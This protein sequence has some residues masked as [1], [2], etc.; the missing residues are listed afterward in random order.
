MM[1]LDELDELL[2]VDEDD[3]WT[4]LPETAG[5]DA[6]SDEEEDFLLDETEAETL[7]YLVLLDQLDAL[8]LAYQRAGDIAEPEPE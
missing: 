1:D 6:F 2:F 8:E 5:D 3:D 4:T 7:R